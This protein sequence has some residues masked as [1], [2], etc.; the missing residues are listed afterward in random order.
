MA[1]NWKCINCQMIKTYP[2]LKQDISRKIQ[3]LYCVMCK[4]KTTHVKL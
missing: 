3:Q 2:L 4:C 1:I